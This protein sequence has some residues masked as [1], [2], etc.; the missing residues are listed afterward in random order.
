MIMSFA[1]QIFVYSYIT[2]PYYI[3]RRHQAII[4]LAN[5][6]E[7]ELFSASVVSLAAERMKEPQSIPDKRT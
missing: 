6:E 2:E 1:L 4:D 5:K 3:Q 7:L